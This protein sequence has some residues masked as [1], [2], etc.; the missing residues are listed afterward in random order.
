M[1]TALSNCCWLKCT[2]APN[3]I[4]MA[5]SRL[6][7]ISLKSATASS[8]AFMAWSCLPFTMC[9][10]A[11][12][13]RACPI[14]SL[15]SDRLATPRAS[16]AALNAFRLASRIKRETFLLSAPRW[17]RPSISLAYLVRCASVI[18]CTKMASLFQ[19]SALR[20]SDLASISRVRA[21][22]GS[23]TASFA[24]ACRCKAAAWPFLW[25]R[26]RNISSAPSA[27]ANALSLA[28]EMALCCGSSASRSTV[29]WATC[30]S[31]SFS[32]AAAVPFLSPS[33]WKSSWASLAKP[34]PSS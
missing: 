14:R 23:S 27:A 20:Q 29:V 11:R 34:M 32:H 24:A 22:S 16:F 17:A 7:P 1:L 21:S 3:V 25:P 33:S 31:A 6:W 12:C 10:R 4:A 9:T 30:R 5:S 8:R 15:L 2:S 19:S 13:M 28:I 26:S 18:N